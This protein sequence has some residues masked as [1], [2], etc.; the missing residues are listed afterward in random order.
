MN[1]LKVVVR[2][3][4]VMINGF[5][6]ESNYAAGTGS[7]VVTFADA[8]AA[9]AKAQANIA[10]LVAAGYVL[11]EDQESPTYGYYVSSDGNTGVRAS[12]EDN[13]LTAN[14]CWLGA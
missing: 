5:D 2:L 13:V 1:N 9:G 12:L 11:D 10:I 8:Q 4:N 14:L 6:V 7:L 3:E